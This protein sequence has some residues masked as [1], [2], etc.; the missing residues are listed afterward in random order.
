MALTEPPEGMVI[1]P[2]LS[3]HSHPSGRIRLSDTVLTVLAASI[4]FWGIL[5]G[6]ANF[7]IIPISAAAVSDDKM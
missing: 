4:W 6:Y 7:P 5:R 3:S 2:A 1:S